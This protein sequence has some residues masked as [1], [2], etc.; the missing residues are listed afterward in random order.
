MKEDLQTILDCMNGVDGGISFVQ[1]KW[2]LEQCQQRYEHHGNDA[3]GDRK[4]L[5]A[6]NLLARVIKAVNKA[7]DTEPE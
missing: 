2:F 1:L 4:I 6:V 7:A 5:E 3:P